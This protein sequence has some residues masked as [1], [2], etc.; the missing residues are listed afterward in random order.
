MGRRPRP[1]LGQHRALAHPAA[2]LVPP[3][4]CFRQMP[5]ANQNAALSEGER[6]RQRAR[7]LS[8]DQERARNDVSLIISY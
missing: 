4:P 8:R 7:A 2:R 6:D 1:S 5:P 3:P